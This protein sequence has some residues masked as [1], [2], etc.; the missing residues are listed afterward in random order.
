M[1]NGDLVQFFRINL[2]VLV[3]DQIPATL[4]SLQ[5]SKLDLE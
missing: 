5:Q 4:D 2:A 3:R 1:L